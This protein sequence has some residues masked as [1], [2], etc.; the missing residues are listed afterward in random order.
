[1]ANGI[2]QATIKNLL[3]PIVQCWPFIKERQLFGVRQPLKLSER[4]RRSLPFPQ[5]YFR[6]QI[7]HESFRCTTPSSINESHDVNQGFA[8]SLK[9][10]NISVAKL[11]KLIE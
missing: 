3:E 1:M 5:A 2:T 9:A 8:A 10:S 11:I 4:S 7:G 6:W